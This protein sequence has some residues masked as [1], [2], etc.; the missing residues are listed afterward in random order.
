MRASVSVII[1]TWNRAHTIRRAIDSALQQSVR[2]L[3]VLVCDDGSTDE[4]ESIVSN[5]AARD[6]RVR[7]IAGERGGRPAIPRNRGLRESR[8]EW[9]AF[10]DSDDDWV[11]GKLETQLEAANRVGARAACSNAT[12]VAVDGHALGALLDWNRPRLTF[13]DLMAVN[14]VVC[15]SCVIH[16]SLLAKIGGF[17]EG[18]EFK[19]VEDYALW[20]RVAALTDF[21]YCRD[22]LV[23]YCDDPEASI[24][25]KQSIAPEKQRRLVLA[26]TGDW[27]RKSEIDPSHRFAA[28][29]ILVF[30][31]GRSAAAALARRMRYGARQ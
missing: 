23:H 8:G 27:L 31:Q 3:E 20:L 25:S 17:P 15:S 30:T 1:P 5:I 13:G 6:S 29:A 21:A 11:P 14:R 26:A 2:V 24:R 7:W 22:T 9:L 10:L 19:A 4:S 12:R 18:P 16:R 28:L